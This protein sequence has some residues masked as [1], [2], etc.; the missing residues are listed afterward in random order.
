[1]SEPELLTKRAYRMTSRA[2]AT[3]RTRERLLHA[4]IDLYTTRPYSGVTLSDLAQQAGVSN[5]TLL[6]HFPSKDHLVQ[7]AAE[8]ARDHVVGQR[9]TAST[10]LIQAIDTLLDHYEVWGDRVLHLLKQEDQVPALRTITDSGRAVHRDWIDRTFAPI[11]PV[12]EPT[13]ARR[14]A[15]LT[16]VCDVQVWKLLRRDLGLTR[17]QTALAL[18]E[19]IS[20]LIPP[21]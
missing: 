1:M 6:R 17:G 19:F 4:A 9:Q 5:P 11:L 21:S 8:S 14:T 20:V 13:R 2:D 10:D 7:A 16:A 18:H 15:Q 12:D 3:A